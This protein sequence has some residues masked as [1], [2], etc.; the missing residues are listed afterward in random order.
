MSGSTTYTQALR[1]TQPGVNNALTLNAWGGLLN[2]DVALIESAI[3]GQSVI[4]INGASTLTLSANN[5]AV[6]QSRAFCLYFQDLTGGTGPC[7]VTIPPVF[8]YGVAINACN[9]TVT[10]TTG[11]GINCALQPSSKEVL[12]RCDG[13]NVFTAI[14]S[15]S[16]QAVLQGG[17][18]SSN[19]I[20]PAQVVRFRIWGGGGNGGQGN[21]YA[22]AGGGGAGYVEALLVGYQGE[23]ATV[24]VG[25]YEQ[26]SSFSGSGFSF[27][28]A[29]GGGGGQGNSAT[30]GYSTGGAGGAATLIGA[31]GFTFSGT[32]APAGYAQVSGSTMT[33]G[34]PSAGGAAFQGTGAPAS[35][36]GQSSTSTN[37]P[38]INALYPGSGGSGGVGSGVG[39]LGASGLILL[40]W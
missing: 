19:F 35:I 17:Y 14:T 20:V 12:Y 13:Q 10:L 34:F 30:G 28:A 1:L 27:V 18:T 8:R 11:S 24:S 15:Q 31:V 36:I 39:G 25:N 38:G 22:G 37:T 21:G 2:T 23:S 6:D 9:Y 4:N 33:F 40:D 3:C 26:Q 29:A 16:N 5:G 7:M 32:S